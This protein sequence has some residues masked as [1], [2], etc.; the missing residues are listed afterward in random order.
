MSISKFLAFDFGAESGRAIIGILENEKIRLEEIHR[1]PNK[2][3]KILGHI[4]W[5]LLA[6]FDE[7]KKS[8]A[9]A[10]QNGHTDIESIGI[11]TWGV[12]FG[13]IGKENNILGF[14]YCYRDSRTNGVMEKLFEIVPRQEVYS[15]TGIQFM[16]FNS[17]FQL[18]SY[19]KNESGLLNIADRLLFMPDLFN[20]M[21]TGEKKSEYSIASTSQMLDAAKR[22]W[23]EKLLSKL[24][25]PLNILPEI[26]RP[27]TVIGKLLPEIADEVGLGEIDVIAP[28][29]HDTG[30]AVAAVPAYDKNWAYLSSGTWSIVGIEAANPIITADSLKYNFTN[31]GGVENTIRFLSNVMG[32][33]LLQ[34]TRKSWQKKGEEY[35][36]EALSKLALDAEP[37]K[38]LIDPDDNSFLNPPDMPAAIIDYCIKR[39][40]TPPSTKGEFIR[41][42][43]ESLALK[44][45]ILVDR[46]NTMQKSK[47]EILHI[48]G[49]GSQNEIL[50]QFTS[51]AC[52]IPVVAGP[53]ECTALGNI[54]VQ[55]VAKGKIESI[56]E[57]RKIIANSFSLKTYMPTNTDKWKGRSVTSS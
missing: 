36:Y 56:S 1:F 24:G 38:C 17:L 53:V 42:I 23:D 7:M 47:I 39:N 15:T 19:Q 37:F 20:F 54:L 45:K 29:C 18:F 5:D 32:M 41:C 11:D 46:I 50:N 4:H 14:P 30:S 16:Q 31:E 33:W 44:Y 2:Q 6:L 34:Q 57:G 52:G 25:L 43:L 27:G 10:I 8:M 48:V 3:I 35:S 55:A 49:G 22:N 40:I 51:D 26:V 13:L 28:A 21:L 12:D 9:I